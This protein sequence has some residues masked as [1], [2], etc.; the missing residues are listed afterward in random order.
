M[1]FVRLCEILQAEPLPAHVTASSDLS[2][3]NA[4]ARGSPPNWCT[5][6]INCRHACKFGISAKLVKQKYSHYW[7][8]LEMS[9]YNIAKLDNWFFFHRKEVSLYVANLGVPWVP[10]SR[11]LF[12]PRGAN[13][14]ARNG[15]SSRGPLRC[16][17][18]TKEPK[19]LVSVVSVWK[20]FWQADACRFS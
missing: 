3:L 16:Q 14:T 6:N 19:H 1:V 7:K 17:S 10:C 20:T 5:A 8:A 2:I 9:Y 18:H 12:S 4:I 11:L 15:R 13:L